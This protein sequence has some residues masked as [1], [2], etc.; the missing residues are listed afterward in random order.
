MKKSTKRILSLVLA[1][2]MVISSFAFVNAD[3]LDEVI[4]TAVEEVASGDAVEAEE[5]VFTAEKSQAEEETAAAFADGTYSTV[6][7]AE[8]AVI[9]DDDNLT[10][11]AICALNS[12][13]KGTG[14]NSAYVNAADNTN[15][16]CRPYV[17]VE[18]KMTGNI[19]AN[20]S[21]DSGKSIYIVEDTGETAYAE[22]TGSGNSYSGDVPIVNVVKK[23]E[24]SAK[25]ITGFI[26]A[27]KTY[28]IAP[29]GTT[30]AMT[31]IEFTAG[32]EPAEETTTEA[33]TEAAPEDLEDINNLT[34]TAPST[35]TDGG[36]HTLWIL[37]DS[38]GCY[39]KEDSGYSVVRNGFGMALGVDA[40]HNNYTPEYM[41][42]D[43]ENLTIQNLAISGI[44]SKSF[45]SNAYYTTLTSNWK[46]GDYVMIAF[47]HN[48]QKDTDATRFTSATDGADGWN[49]DGQFANSLYEN[50]ILPAVK[51][52]V[53]PILLTSTIRRSTNASGPSGSSIHSTSYGDYRQTVIDLG[54]KF[55]IPVIDTTY[56]TYA[57]CIALGAGNNDGSDG[58][59]V[60]HAIKTDGSI[61]NTHLNAAGARMV[62][63]F[64]AKTILGQEKEFGVKATTPSTI[65]PIITDC[66]AD[67]NNT[68]A[69]IATFLGEDASIDPR[70]GEYSG[71][72]TD[73]SDA[74]KVYLDYTGD[75]GKIMAGDTFNVDVKTVNN[76]GIGKI[77]LELTY[78]SQEATP[79][80]ANAIV[81]GAGNVLVSAADY[82]AAVAAQKDAGNG[83]YTVTI[84][85]SFATPITDASATMFSV[86][87]T[88]VKRGDVVID[89]AA[90]V[91][92]ATGTAY[93]SDT[94]KVVDLGINTDE[95]ITDTGL[96]L[97]PV[98]SEIVDGKFIVDYV[99]SGNNESLG[100]NNATLAIN[101][102]PTVI[103]AI[104]KGNESVV[105]AVDS[106]GK[107][108]E[109]IID[110]SVID[111]QVAVVP[112]ANDTDY[113]GADGVKTA[114]ELGTIKVAGYLADNDGDSKVDVAYNN[115]I[116]FS[117][118][119]EIVNADA[120]TSNILEAATVN[121]TAPVGG[122]GSTDATEA[123]VTIE[124][125]YVKTG[126][127]GDVDQS[128]RITANDTAALLTFVRKSED[129][130]DTWVVENYIADVNNDNVVDT[131]DAAEILLKVLNSAH[132]F[133]RK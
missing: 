130:K 103:K 79:A 64:M 52:G 21:I 51:A 30:P 131:A 113:N 31:S 62:A 48:D 109:A 57:E 120:D 3:A 12:S 7:F 106:A 53:T 49:I 56:N 125:N 32:N 1:F 102:D 14:I 63:F 118:K 86:P 46:S 81:D 50:Y 35:A 26:E 77:S 99:L 47:G 105:G 121:V 6:N 61:D 84:E 16:V 90:T 110:A 68:F 126:L 107:L 36:K 127:V 42:F 38:T 5:P 23:V 97:K 34:R 95:D 25:A 24:G 92:D 85:A 73:D 76:E 122:F 15:I 58:Y 87:F 13:G 28:Y 43:N 66:S 33:T 65:T 80:T 111:T 88:L 29:S 124:D 128:G 98:V 20:C 22:W 116:L 44:S 89:A 78:D 114:A 54:K 60:Y 45:L 17:K 82:A 2:A 71:G 72:D 119:Y 104:G 75:A 74:F 59:A 132:Q 41:I 27:G 9:A 40:A 83:K 37:G 133:A 11:T 70:T 39:Y 19:T 67:A 93:P 112:E 117:I 69:A 101:Y 10:L 4:A 129:A 18:A 55:N 123:D 94:V 91:Y 8:G 100:L 115:G 108:V 96:T